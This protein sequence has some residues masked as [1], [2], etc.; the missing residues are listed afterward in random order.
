MKP[1]PS[2]AARAALASAGIAV[3]QN[4]ET[5]TSAQIDAVKAEAS[6]VRRGKPPLRNDAGL[7]SFYGLLQRRAATRPQRA[8]AAKIG[9]A[10]RWTRRE[11]RQWMERERR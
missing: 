9:K 5:L 3:G 1:N 11:V 2:V 4:F 7:R 8:T 6:R 10:A